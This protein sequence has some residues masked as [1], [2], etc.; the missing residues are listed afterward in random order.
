MKLLKP[1]VNCCQSNPGTADSSKGYVI[2]ISASP[3]MSGIAKKGNGECVNQEGFSQEDPV[4]VL[5]K[6]ITVKIY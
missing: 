4:V 6:A 2:I 3:K 1:S 5:W